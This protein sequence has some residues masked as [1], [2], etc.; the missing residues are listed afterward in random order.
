MNYNIHQADFIAASDKIKTLPKAG[1]KEVCIVGRSNVG[2]SSLI[3]KL[4]GRKSL[5]R[6]GK[7]PGSTKVICLYGIKFYNADKK[8]K[9]LEFGV[10]ADLPGYGYAKTSNEK[11]ELW[12][13]LICSYITTRKALRAVVLL[14]DIRR[15][16]GEDE[17]QILDLVNEDGI[18][19]CL[20]KADKLTKNELN[21]RLNYFSKEIDKP[22][23]DI[24]CVS[25]HDQSFSSSIE[26]L[27][28]FICSYF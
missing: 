18:M 4:V 2:K 25:S 7:M 1:G 3:N 8:E 15:D 28:D 26:K 13:D 19:L 14:V 27:N 24:L 11:R 20:T 10:L 21:K 22:K 6:V 23:E 16:L 5:A 17:R 9:K 12:S